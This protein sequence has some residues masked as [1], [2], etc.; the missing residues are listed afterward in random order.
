MPGE[1]LVRM[2]KLA[3]TLVEGTVS[4]WLKSVGEAVAEG[5]PLVE[6]E[7]DKV[8]T[9]L[10]SPFGGVLV[11][12]VSPEGRTV[13]VDA[14]IGRIGSGGAGGRGDAGTRGRGDEE[15]ETGRRGDRETGRGGEGETGRAGEET[16]A[17]GIQGGGLPGA[18]VQ[19]PRATSV[20]ARLLSEHGLRVEEVAE[21]A[22][23][24]RVMK[25]DVLDYVESRGAPA[26][27]VSQHAPRPISTTVPD[28]PSPHP[29]VSPAAPP[30][31]TPSPATPLPHALAP[32]TLHPLTGARQVRERIEGGGTEA[33]FTLQPLTSMRRA[34]AEHMARARATIPHGQTVMEVDVTRLVAWREKEKSAFQA[35]EGANL[36]YTVFFLAA[37][38]RALRRVARDL[39]LALPTRAQSVAIDLGLAVAL[40]G[41]L[42]VPVVREVDRL[43]LGEMARA[44]QDLADRARAGKLAPN[45]TTGAVMSVTN[46]GSFGNLTAFPIVPLNQVG[47]LGP[48]VVEQR[49]LPLG[50]GGIRLGW[51]CL[52][53]LVFDRRV[54]SDFAADRFVY[55]PLARSG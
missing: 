30:P 16:R 47:I 54:L 12:Q 38:G 27:D 21:G 24:R 32:S 17:A 6:I 25:A 7:T 37:L 39:E 28:H 23:G 42:I 40:D 26:R 29:L 14:V 35:R 33:P 19:R 31:L 52:L 53:A 48:G 36:T 1:M 20:A 43:S 2:P 15:R 5:E 22:P 44:I 10:P 8:T 51:R 3:D 34:I 50:D 41:G 45:E 55:E 46:V 13:P 4:R 9:E 18:V 11:E 49:P